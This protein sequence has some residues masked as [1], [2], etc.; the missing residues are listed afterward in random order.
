MIAFDTDV[1]TEILL[2]NTKYVS[3]ASAIPELEQAVPIIVIEEIIRGRLN[4]I[5]QAEAGNSR[6]SI[7][8]AYELFEET[9]CDFR[10]VQVLSY[11]SEAELFYQQW[12]QQKIR[13]GTHD[14]RI[15]AIC[16]AH[17]AKLVSRNRRDFEYVPD[18]KVEFWS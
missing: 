12:R 9:F 4:G 14:L 10:R 1:L 5:R 11:T 6:I 17:N 16:I 7:E 3:C 13:V 2:G 18:L 8:R 15:A